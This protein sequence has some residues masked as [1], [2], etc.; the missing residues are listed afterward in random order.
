MSSVLITAGPT[1]ESIDSVRYLSNYS[2]GKMGYA[3]AHSARKRNCKVI[4]ISGPSTE[5]PPENIH[6]IS[7]TT[8]KE[9]FKAVEK[10][11]LSQDIA[12]HC[13][14]VSDYQVT[15]PQTNKIKKQTALS[16]ELEKT[17]DIL[18]S[19]RKQ[20]GFQGTLIGFAAETQNLK[21]NAKKK[22]L[23]KG[24]DLIIANDVSSGKIFGSEENK[25]CLISRNE[26]KDLPQMEKKKLA[27]ILMDAIL[28]IHQ[29]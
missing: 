13:A 3:L 5:I 15:Q 9:M 20:M 7:V 23:Q 21:E 11:I 2:S 28:K 24:C 18:A 8:A 10:N 17:P 4:L 25:V 16:L 22:L 6:F 1:R 14:A 19:C 29:G 26:E 27:E 12:I